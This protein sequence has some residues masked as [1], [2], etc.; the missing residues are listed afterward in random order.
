MKTYFTSVSQTDH[1]NQSYKQNVR[2]CFPPALCSKLLN[3][4]GDMERAP[5]ELLQDNVTGG[6][7][8]LAGRKRIIFLA[9]SRA[10]DDLLTV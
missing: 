1:S 3:R 10:A 5:P 9:R 7:W 2:S 4:G 8:P 6:P